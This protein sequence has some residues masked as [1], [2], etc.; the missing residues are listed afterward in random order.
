[1]ILN[2]LLMHF[3]NINLLLLLFLLLLIVLIIVGV[4]VVLGP[5]HRLMVAESPDSHGPYS[6]YF[7]SW[8][9]EVKKAVDYKNQ[10]V[11]IIIIIIIIIIEII[12]FINGIIIIIFSIVIYISIKSFY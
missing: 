8:F 5:A 7:D 3:L 6:G 1:M 4:V 2:L 9:G 12:L 10:K 11:I